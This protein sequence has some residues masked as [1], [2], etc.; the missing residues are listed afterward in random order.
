MLETWHAPVAVVVAVVVVVAVAVA[1]VGAVWHDAGRMA[2]SVGRRQLTSGLCPEL[3]DGV[4]WQLK[5]GR[6]LA[7]NEFQVCL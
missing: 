1:V 5:L 7:R 2:S 4:A 3:L 6:P